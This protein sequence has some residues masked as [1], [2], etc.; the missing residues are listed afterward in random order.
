VA[1]R[2][3]RA[4]AAAAGAAARGRGLRGEEAAAS[5][6]AAR[7]YSILARNFRCRGGEIDIIAEREGA[8]AFVEVKSWRGL[9]KADL[10]YAVGPRKRRRLQL[11]A[12]YF[13][14]G[15]P[16]LGGRRLRF[17]VV[18]L[19]GGRIEHL[20]DAFGGSVD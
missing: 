3:A 8:L 20:E 2:A 5:W 19:S 12:R 4:T 1:E 11:A 9:G 6:L 14:A 13:L 17:D 10:E 15:R 18:L 7:G 16:N